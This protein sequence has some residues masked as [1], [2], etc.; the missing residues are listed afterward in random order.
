MEPRGARAP[1]VPGPRRHRGWPLILVG[2]VVSVLVGLP[3]ALLRLRSAPSRRSGTA[4]VHPATGVPSGSAAGVLVLLSQRPGLLSDRSDVPRGMGQGP[5]EAGVEESDERSGCT[6]GASACGPTRAAG[7][8][9]R[10]ARGGAVALAAASV[11]VTGQVPPSRTP[12][13]GK[14]V[15]P[16][17]P[18]AGVRAP[19][20]FGFP[21]S[22]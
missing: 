6:P 4:G 18:P 17:P 20:A 10:V 7:A 16:G 8:R 15:R 12:S 22:G 19:A 21:P 11:A 14:G 9:E 1:R 2:C 3:A 13:L 5:A